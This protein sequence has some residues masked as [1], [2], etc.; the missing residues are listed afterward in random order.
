MIAYI[1]LIV[2]LLMFNTLVVFLFGWLL[3]YIFFDM[4]GL[5]KE[6]EEDDRR[7]MIPWFI[8]LGIVSIGIT[9]YEVVTI[10]AQ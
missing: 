4:A 1:I 5:R 8:F 2:V 7:I 6:Y 3:G 10:S 9:I